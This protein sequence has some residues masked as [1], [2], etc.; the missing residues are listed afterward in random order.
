MLENNE[1]ENEWKALEYIGCD[2][3]NWINRKYVCWKMKKTDGKNR[4]S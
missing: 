4:T 2:V 1:V 3:I